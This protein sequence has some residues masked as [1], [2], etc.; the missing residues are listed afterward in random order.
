M[1]LFASALA[2]S[3]TPSE[4][5]V[6]QPWAGARGIRE[7]VASIMKREATTPKRLEPFYKYKEKTGP[8]RT[9]LIENPFAMPISQWPMPE[10]LEPLAV[11]PDRGPLFSFGTQFDA[12]N[13]NEALAWPPDTMG[14]VGPTQVLVCINGRIKVFD[15]NGN[16]GGLNAAT[17]VFFN[18]VRRANTFTTDPR[19]RYDRA[20]GRWFI[21]MIDALGT[22][23]D[24]N[25]RILLAVSSGSTISNSSSFTFF[26]FAQNS[27]S[28]AGDDNAFFDYPTLGIDGNALYIGGNNFT[29]GFAGT[30]AFVVRKSSL[31]SGGPIVVTAFRNLINSTTGVGLFTPQG[32]DNDDPTDPSGWFIGVDNATFGTIMMRKVT[33]PGG[34]PT[35]GPNL[36]VS[37][38]LATR[39]PLD[40]H[41]LGTSANRKVDA[42][43]DRLFVAKI[44]TN[45]VTGERTLWTAHNVGVNSGG[46]SSSEDRTGSRWYEIENLATS[47]SVKQAGTLFDSSAN[48]T[49]YWMPAMTMTGQ[50]IALLGGNSAGDS[51][52]TSIS[53]AQHLP[54]TTLGTLE[55]PLDAIVS[56]A[57]Y[58]DGSGLGTMRWGDYS[59]TS[60]DPN[61]DM[62]A[63]T[64]QMY[65]QTNTQW[66]VRVVKLIAPPPAAI[67][68]VTGASAQP[69]NNTVVT[70]NGTSSSGVGFFDPG[71]GFANRLA[72][73][74]SGSGV[75]VSNI[76]FINPT[77]IKFT[78]T[79]DSGATAGTRNITVTN[80][81]GQQVTA[82]GVFTVESGGTPA[83][84]NLYLSPVTVTGGFKTKIKIVLGAA[85][86]AGGV[87]VSL[88][89]TDPVIPVPST[90]TVPAGSTFA[91]VQ[92]TTVP[93]QNITKADVTASFNGTNITKTGTVK[94]PAVNSLT[95]DPTSVASGSTTKVRGVL[96][97]G[98]KAP[99][100]GFLVNVSSSDKT[101]VITPATVTVPA[102]QTQVGFNLTHYRVASDTSVTITAKRGTA[103]VTANLG[104]TSSSVFSLTFSSSSV[105]GGNPVTATVKLKSPAPAGGATVLLSSS[106]G[107]AT[108]PVSVVVP[109]GQT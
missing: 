75:S 19:V 43:D 21:V 51:K 37:G 106:S 31:T 92:V 36:T 41:P 40:I 14:D 78:A 63:W 48:K 108:V 38:V 5:L 7:S 52:R 33:D 93:V 100:G 27:P 81:D 6:G 59:H 39:F 1:A 82:N 72:V 98:G 18:S 25:N 55:A 71:A 76:Q 23:S 56:S 34:T 86:P 66:G 22:S 68:S 26:Q 69:G 16:L 60:V 45:R 105:T 97:L 73:S 94:P 96:R 54:S 88:S 53:V 107:S 8:D 30:T 57:D 62:T 89:S 10:R 74:V 102:G 95:L 32:V 91:T 12:T 47:P 83:L 109:A 87:T 77:Q 99:A 103:S 80:P 90:L 20:T 24:K 61:D 2:F 15:K 29:P 50:G 44:R 85:A 4:T 64:F 46:A 9:N 58:N 104:L 67:S 49:G 101:K 65:A 17:D 35:L 79:V 11:R 70:V 3:Q 28:P 84:T 42:L 13:F